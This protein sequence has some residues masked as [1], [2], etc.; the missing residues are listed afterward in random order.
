MP[1]TT[2]T[3]TPAPLVPAELSSWERD[4]WQEGYAL[5]TYEAS[6]IWAADS[7]CLLDESDVFALF[8]QHGASVAEYRQALAWLADTGGHCLPWQHAGQALTW[9]GY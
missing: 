8:Q 4:A 5:D 1:T 9:L 7:E 2:T 6:V 3:T